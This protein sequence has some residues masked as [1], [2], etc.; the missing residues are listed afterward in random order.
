[1][2]F[3]PVVLTG[4]GTSGIF[5]LINIEKLNYIKI[6]LFYLFFSCNK[7]R[8]WRR[9]ISSLVGAGSS[10]TSF[11]GVILLT[12]LIKKKTTRAIIKKLITAFKKLPYLN[13]AS[14]IVN[15]KLERSIF[16]IN[17]P[18]RG[19]IKSLTKEFTI[20]VKAAPIINPTAKSIMLPRE[21]NS[22][23]SLTMVDPLSKKYLLIKNY[24]ESRNGNARKMPIEKTL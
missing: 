16:P 18:I 17:N 22:L 21:I 3:S 10:S 8:I 13:V 11:L 9:Y 2:N 15:F 12:N 20:A 19:L 6:L 14:P 7:S 23:N 4:A 5:V 24:I 1:M